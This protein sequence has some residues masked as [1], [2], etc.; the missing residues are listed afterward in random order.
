MAARYRLGLNNER[1][2]SRDVELQQHKPLLGLLLEMLREWTG[3]FE[4]AAAGGG[5]KQASRRSRSSE[6]LEQQ[7][8]LG[9]ALVQALARLVRCHLYW[10][11]RQEREGQLLALEDLEVIEVGGGWLAGCPGPKW[12]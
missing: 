6:G 8:V 3:R 12:C 2:L 1:P 7:A 9:A 5:R 4:A 10:V 11:Q